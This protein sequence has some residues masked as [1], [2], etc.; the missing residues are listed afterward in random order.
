MFII[1]I[2]I[3]KNVAYLMEAYIMVTTEITLNDK[4]QCKD[5]FK[6]LHKELT[7][8]METAV[9]IL[10]WG[11]HWSVSYISE[12]NKELKSFY[13]TIA[14]EHNY[15]EININRH[16]EFL[17]VELSLFDNISETQYN[18]AYTSTVLHNMIS[19]VLADYLNFKFCEEV[20]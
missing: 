20:K 1:I 6:K 19:T 13:L 2:S 18:D 11:Q 16:K 14:S 3:Y 7:R 5:L 17:V 12:I 15:M 4:K 9:N 8:R 10:H